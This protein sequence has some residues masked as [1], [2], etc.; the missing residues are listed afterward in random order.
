LE[1]HAELLVDAALP[2]WL[3]ETVWRDRLRQTG[4]WLLARHRDRWLLDYLASPAQG[5]RILADAIAA[6]QSGDHL[7]ALSDAA[8]AER[9]FQNA[10]NRAGRLRAGVER[11]YALQRMARPGDCLVAAAPLRRE[12][13]DLPYPWVRSQL[14]L[15]I[16]ACR[17]ALGQ[18]GSG[19]AAMERALDEARQAGYRGLELRAVSFTAA[20]QGDLGNEPKVWAPTLDALSGFW[21]GP[22]RPLRGQALLL[23]L[24]VAA[25]RAGLRYAA[26]VLRE[27][28]VAVLGRDENRLIVA[29]SRSKLGSAA[30]AAGEREAAMRALDEADVLLKA[31]DS[32]P[33]ARSYR[34]EAALTGASLLV[35][36]RQAEM[37]VRRL[38]TMRGTEK[39]SLP[40]L[41]RI[42][43]SETLGLAYQQMGKER[44]AEAAFT[45]AL[46]R[47][48]D[49]ARSMTGEQARTAALQAAGE[50]SRWLASLAITQRNDWRGALRIWDEHR[51]GA[52]PSAD[53]GPGKF[54]VIAVLPQGV[55]AWVTDGASLHSKW[56][57]ISGDDL[58]VSA[59]E[60]LRDCANPASAERSWKSKAR[61]LYDRI[62][63]PLAAWL[64]PAGDLVIE[65]DGPLARIPFAALLDPAGR[66]LGDRFN[67]VIN[68]NMAGWSR[69][70]RGADA[71]LGRDGA[72]LVVSDPELRGSMRHRYP[73]LDHARQEAMQIAGLYPRTRVIEGRL[74]TL[75]A[76][77][78]AMPEMKIF[79]FAGHAI[80]GGA[81]GLLLAPEGEG[82]ADILNADRLAAGTWDGCELVV[83]SACSTAGESGDV[84]DPESLVNAFLAGGVPRVIASTWPVD[85]ASTQRFM[86][87]LYEAM[88]AG[89]AASESLRRAAQ[90]LRSGGGHPYYWAGFQI[91]GYR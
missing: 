17:N 56:L 73:P 49:R 79:H 32:N 88:A 30:L 57:D 40:A 66:F 16:G 6:N 36:T 78:G 65:A 55:A 46:L 5:S 1:P 69:R 84:V 75:G 81:R 7:R 39:A 14:D 60:F 51:G 18:T 41:L 85:S 42:K 19:L 72:V 8:A 87:Q 12:S 38:V 23:N 10:G 29:L 77:R 62:I 58:N 31:L 59:T 35:E 47:A 24:S 48:R 27:E 26:Y 54:I 76:I 74:A 21:S 33:A 52:E 53:G 4:A 25:E 28:A 63:A 71:V 50:S 86:R 45:D 90:S 20:M 3:K 9:Q 61:S 34:D 43:L 15:E 82:E 2:T 22:H 80:S 64:G 44:E 37:A 13:E 91:Y 83:L 67:I 11:V 89:N 68:D 70:A